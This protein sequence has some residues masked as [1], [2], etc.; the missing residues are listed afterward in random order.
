[1]VVAALFVILQGFS[2]C[3]LL[4]LN[5]RVKPYLFKENPP[6]TAVSVR[7]YLQLLF[8]FIS[9]TGYK[10]GVYYFKTLI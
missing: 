5:L 2:D 8:G 4:C 9:L 7:L 3:L 6:A 10:P 1:M